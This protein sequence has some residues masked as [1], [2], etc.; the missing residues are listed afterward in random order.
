M[1]PGDDVMGTTMFAQYGGIVSADVMSRVGYNV[2]LATETDIMAG[3]SVDAF[4]AYRSVASY[5]IINANL[6]LEN[7]PDLQLPAHTVLDVNGTKVGVFGLSSERGR[8]LAH[9]GQTAAMRDTDQVIQDNLAYFK[10]EGI[11]I[12]VLLSSLGVARDQQ[13]AQK[14]G[15]PDGI[16][17]IIGNGDGAVLGKPED[18]PQGG[19]TPI[20]PYPLVFNEATTPTLLV[21]A[22]SFAAYMGELNLTFDAQGILKSWDGELH[23]LDDKVKPDPDMQQYVDQLVSGL[24]LDKV[25]IGTAN[26]DLGGEYDQ[27][28]WQEN[29]LSNL[30]ADIYLDYGKIF[31]A[32]ISLVNAGATWGNLKKGPLT[33][34][35]LYQAQPYF[36]WL[37]VEDITGEQLQAA[38]ENSVATYGDMAEPGP[39]L[40]SAGVTYTFDPILP[41]G[42]R[43][44]EAAVNGK[45]IDPK[46]TYVVAVNGFMADGG[47]NYTM[48]SEGQNIFNTGLSV[49]D[50]IRQYFQQHSPLDMP[51]MGRIKQIGTI[52]LIRP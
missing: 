23:A 7:L 32:Q 41:V 28:A 46:Q 45:P 31:G 19:P 51:Q 15:G 48:L 39:F 13:V 18:F 49:T 11:D 10:S 25:V 38:L 43:I 40:H 5:P 1:S 8:A 47:D 12:V 14:Y 4:R 26:V 22:G 42:H 50:I 52:G 17:V 24:A 6:D 20:G 37:I 3:G 21:Y 36:N 30:W 35:D 34:S 27:Y 33:L 16:D 29:A 2:A 9:F 44:V